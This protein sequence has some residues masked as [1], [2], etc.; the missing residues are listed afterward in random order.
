MQLDLSTFEEP[1]LPLQKAAGFGRCRRTGQLQPIS[2]PADP[3][4]DLVEGRL[5]AVIESARFRVCL[6][7]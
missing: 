7:P 2:P 1:A 4:K 3:F 6:S 5:A